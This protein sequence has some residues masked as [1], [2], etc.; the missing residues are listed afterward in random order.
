MSRTARLAPTA[1]VLIGLLGA[2]GAPG[3]GKAAEPLVLRCQTNGDGLPATY[4]FRVEEPR[5]PL[6]STEPRLSLVGVAVAIP[7][8][9]ESHQSS[10]VKAFLATS[11]PDWPTGAARMDIELNMMTGAVRVDFNGPR[12]TNGRSPWFSFVLRSQRGACQRSANP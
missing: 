5:F 11:Q 1:C 6:F 2:V 12:I 4:N 8:E 9:I 10:V 7:L 3:E